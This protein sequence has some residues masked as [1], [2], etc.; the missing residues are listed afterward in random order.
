MNVVVPPNSAPTAVG[1]GPFTVVQGGAL[2]LT[3]GQ[4]LGNDIDPDK[5]YG[6]VLSVNSVYA[7][8]GSVVNNVAAKTVTFTPVAG[9]TGPAS[10]IYRVKDASG[11]VSANT[12]TVNVTVAAVNIA[13][14]GLPQAPLT[15]GATGT[16]YQVLGRGGVGFPTELAVVTI[17]PD[18]S[19]V[20][21]FVVATSS[22]II[23]QT[24]VFTRPDGSIVVVAAEDTPIV[25]II[26]VDTSGTVA[27]EGTFTGFV[28]GYAVLV[29]DDGTVY[30]VMATEKSVITFNG[31]TD[32]K[33]TFEVWR[34]T[35]DGDFSTHS[36]DL[37]NRQVSELGFSFTEGQLLGQLGGN[38]NLYVP[39]ES[40][41]Y[42]T[43]S[44]GLERSVSDA[45]LLVIPRTGSAYGFR[46]TDAVID[47]SF[48]GSTVSDFGV[49]DDGTA[50]LVASKSFLIDE[51]F[52]LATT[53]LVVRSNGSISE[54]VL[55]GGRIDSD[56]GPGGAY[57]VWEKD[58]SPT[59]SVVGTTGIGTAIPVTIDGVDFGGLS[60]VAPDGTR[61]ILNE[62]SIVSISSSGV[63]F[64]EYIGT[65]TGHLWIGPDST[66][67]AYAYNGTDHRVVKVS[68][69]SLQSV[70]LGGV[71]LPDGNEGDFT[72]LVKFA[73]DGTPWIGVGDPET[74]TAW[75]TNL[76][77]GVASTT[78]PADFTFS[79]GETTPY[80]FKVVSDSAYL[81][82]SSEN[83]THILAVGTDDETEFS[84]DLSIGGQQGALAAVCPDGTAYLVFAE[85]LGGS[86]FSTQ[87]WA[88][89]AAGAANV[90]SAAGLPAGVT[91]GSDGTVFATI[92]EIDLG[93][94]SATT[95]IR[96]IGGGLSSL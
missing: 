64:N 84:Y 5:P 59:L 4:L 60:E 7:S 92:V 52:G 46:V 20:E 36:Y 85:A 90:L 41:R 91:V 34:L 11:A 42:G 71:G 26:S 17:S 62:D 37:G 55:D 51:E 89:G 79:G 40:V 8:S 93:T 35:P 95:T 28:G 27:V 31:Q 78:I 86:S 96:S 19:A 47:D 56:I 53:V 57:V 32:T 65:N 87:V 66:A 15:F 88:A 61:F 68:S 24:E 67:Y 45:A 94:G 33:R 30:Q 44:E 9:Y 29:A 58:G 39:F 83:G 14:E 50:Y 2:T 3:W 63:V 10:F 75:I 1:D 49:A 12:A 69:G 74:Q 80:Q 76:A 6:D 54:Y 38:G 77:T 72:G 70:Q 43:T 13:A 23:V 82:F 48:S 81:S 21:N 16:A 22:G 18:G 25:H 73:S